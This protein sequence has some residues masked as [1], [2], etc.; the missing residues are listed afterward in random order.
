MI[1]NPVLGRVL[2]AAGGASVSVFRQYWENVSRKTFAI[3][4]IAMSLLSSL[5]ISSGSWQ[6]EN[7]LQRTVFYPD[8]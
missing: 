2:H 7:S 6:G 8:R 4:I 1:S 5:V 3:L